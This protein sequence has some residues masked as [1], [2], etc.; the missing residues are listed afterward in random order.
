MTYDVDG[1][2]IQSI[3]LSCHLEKSYSVITIPYQIRCLHFTVRR[4]VFKLMVDRY[5]VIFKDVVK[6]YSNEKKC[7]LLSQVYSYAT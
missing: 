3:K 7:S 6:C 4:R 2:D 1:Y 5:K